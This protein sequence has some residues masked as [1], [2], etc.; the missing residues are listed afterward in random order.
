MRP[1]CIANQRQSV[2]TTLRKRTCESS[3]SFRSR[4][5][6]PLSSAK[7]LAKARNF[8]GHLESAVAPTGEGDGISANEN[9][10]MPSGG[11]GR[12]LVSPVERLS[13]HIVVLSPR[14]Q[15]NEFG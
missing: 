15:R 14:Q 2:F 11:W 13:R 9:R 5:I 10:S 12:V 4:T 1:N 7:P 3:D 8:L 6:N